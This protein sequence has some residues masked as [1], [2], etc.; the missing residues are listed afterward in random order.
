MSE[1][2]N[3]PLHFRPA[4]RAS[5]PGDAVGGDEVAAV[6]PDLGHAA[7]QVSLDGPSL[8]FRILTE[9]VTTQ[10]YVCKRLL[11]GDPVREVRRESEGKVEVQSPDGI[12]QRVLNFDPHPEYCEYVPRHTFLG[13]LRDCGVAHVTVCVVFG[14]FSASGCRVLLQPSSVHLPQ[15][16]QRFCC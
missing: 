3:L 15:L 6:E 13:K 11:N 8:E 2:N 4:P 1:I 9:R 10:C 5:C 7:A 16:S 12:A 14:C